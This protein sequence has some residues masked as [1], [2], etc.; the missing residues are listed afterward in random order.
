MGC[1]WSVDRG[2]AGLLTTGSIFGRVILRDAWPPNVATL[3]KVLKVKWTHFAR[4]L[5]N[6]IMIRIRVAFL[7][8]CINASLKMR[9]SWESSER[10]RR[11]TSA[12][13]R[14][15]LRLLK[16]WLIIRLKFSSLSFEE[17]KT[18]RSLLKS[19]FAIAFEEWAAS[20]KHLTLQI[21]SWIFVVT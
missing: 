9:Y 1:W 21:P 10:M 15:K 19:H 20:L 14:R 11:L 4:P 6:Q 18:Q 12:N 2:A 5:V 16:Q 17:G 13:Q 7:T 3:P 8:L